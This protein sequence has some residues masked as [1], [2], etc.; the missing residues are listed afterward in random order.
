MLNMT[1]REDKKTEKDSS[2]GK[3]KEV[4]HLFFAGLPLLKKTCMYVLILLF[5]KLVTCE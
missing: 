2:T 1:D 5:K 4:D 3:E